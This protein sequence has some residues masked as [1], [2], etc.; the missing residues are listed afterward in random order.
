MLFVI[1]E[2]CLLFCMPLPILYFGARS[3]RE[4]L[5]GSQISWQFWLFCFD[6]NE[7]MS[8]SLNYFWSLVIII[9]GVH[10][11]TPIVHVFAMHWFLGNYIL[12]LLVYNLIHLYSLQFLTACVWP[13][14]LKNILWNLRFLAFYW[15]FSTNHP[16][17]LFLAVFLNYVF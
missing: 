4:N 11:Y 9:L 6:L 7:M 12:G 8:A 2:L 3:I 15:Y 16:A 5:T 17:F 1:F 13:R 14:R 10:L